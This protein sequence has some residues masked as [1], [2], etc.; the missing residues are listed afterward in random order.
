LKPKSKQF[1]GTLVKFVDHF[2]SMEFTNKL[3]ILTKV[4]KEVDGENWKKAANE[5]FQSFKVKDA[6]ELV[7][8]PK[9]QN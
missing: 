7:P 2:T 3:V 6:W 5:Q 8:F 1:R 4:L 9:G